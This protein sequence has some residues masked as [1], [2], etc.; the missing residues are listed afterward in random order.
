CIQ[1]CDNEAPYQKVAFQRS[2]QRF[3]QA[4]QSSTT[5]S[6]IWR[7]YRTDPSPEIFNTSQKTATLCSAYQSNACENLN[8]R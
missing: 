4:H 5:R 1:R 8:E 6:E 3:T 7:F 2:R